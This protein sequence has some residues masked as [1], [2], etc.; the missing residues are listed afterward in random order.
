MDSGRRASGLKSELQFG[1]LSGGIIENERLI[2]N[3]GWMVQFC[4]D[5]ELSK[6]VDIGLG[7]GLQGLEEE[8]ILPVFLDIKARMKDREHSP[9]LAVNIGGTK[10]WSSTYRNLSNFDY[11]GGFYFSTYYAFDFPINEKM[12]LLIAM[13]YIHQNGEIEYSAEG[14]LEFEEDFSL[15]YLTLRAGLRF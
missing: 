11:E 1:M 8:T 9:F 3:P 2:Y 12:S 4:V 13:G 15:D 6:A 5:K 10:G 7:V 14:D